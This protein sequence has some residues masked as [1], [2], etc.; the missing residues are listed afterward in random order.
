ME[1][2]LNG[3]NILITNNIIDLVYIYW[4]NII[5]IRRHFIKKISLILLLVLS[6]TLFLTGC[7]FSFANYG[8][9]K[10]VSG[11]VFFE[12]EPLSGVLIQ[13][14]LTTFATTNEEGFYTFTTRLTNLTIKAKKSGYNFQPKNITIEQDSS[15]QYNFFGSLAVL[16]NGTLNLKQILISPTSIVSIPDNNYSY[17]ANST[18]N[19]KISEFMLNFNREDVIQTSQTIML[20]KNTYTNILSQDDNLEIEIVDGK[21]NYR[22]EFLLKAYFTYSNGQNESIDNEDNLSILSVSSTLDTGDLDDD[23]QISFIARGI[24]ST[25]DGYTYNVKFVFQFN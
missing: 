14:E 19:L 11:H 22:F 12:D 4:Y 8:Q 1:K 24:N 15:L 5:Y 16:L 20:A 17:Y 18:I 9:S 13:N 10:T 23:S 6:F 3:N 25:S 7:E 2:I 21:T